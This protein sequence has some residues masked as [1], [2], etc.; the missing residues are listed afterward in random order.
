MNKTLGYI[1][2]G[3]GLLI[4]L[5]SY[6]GI[7]TALGINLPESSSDIYLVILGL[8]L[9]FIGAYIALKRTEKMIEVPIYKG[10]DVVGY[11]VISQK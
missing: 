3:I 11:R 10:K 4:F 7:R 6:P 9:I 5:F 2:A 1:L 8:I